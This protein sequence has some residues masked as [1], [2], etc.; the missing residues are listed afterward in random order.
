[1]LLW[2]AAAQTAN[3]LAEKAY[4]KL[5]ES[6]QLAPH[7]RRLQLEGILSDEDIDLL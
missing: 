6:I 1:M 4:Q 5:K 7:R 3:A 2:K